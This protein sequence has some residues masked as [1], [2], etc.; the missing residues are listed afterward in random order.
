MP[1]GKSNRSRDG[2]SNLVDRIGIGV[3]DRSQS[4]PPKAIESSQ[5][6]FAE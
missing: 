1:L 4:G 6:D 3:A 5:L 2:S